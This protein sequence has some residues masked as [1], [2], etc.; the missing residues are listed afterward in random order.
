MSGLRLTLRQP[1]P[2]GV[3]IDL[4]AL[5]SQCLKELSH[6]QIG[7]L[8]LNIGNKTDEIGNWFAV[9][10]CPCGRI[11]LCGDLSQ[12][13]FIGAELRDSEIL[14]DGNV[15]DHLGQN[16]RSG[17][18][19]VQG[20]AGQYCGGQLTGGS[21][22]VCGDV[23]HYAGGARVGERRGMQGGILVIQGNA[24]SHAGHRMRRGCLLIHGSS[25]YALGMRMIAGT[26]AACGKTGIGVGCGMRRG[27][28]L[29]F[30]SKR[31]NGGAQSHPGFTEAEECELSF[32][33]ILL[34]SLYPH[35]PNHILQRLSDSP[36]DLPRRGIRC[37]GDRAIS[38]LGEI[39]SL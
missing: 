13:D 39:I 20:N 21:I 6:S 32:L 2:T 10:S 4:S 31:T 1:P 9:E 26:I 5:T 36:I 34:S 29:L 14:I 38:G 28:I 18:I 24:G 33:P 12:F 35:L 8:Q 15:G 25:D 22:V 19:L 23:G 17:T 11:E 30:E 3:R 16:M 7:Q 27:T 37:L